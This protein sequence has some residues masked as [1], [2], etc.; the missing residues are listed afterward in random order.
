MAEQIVITNYSCGLASSGSTQHCSE[1]RLEMV[2]VV[3]RPIHIQIQIIKIYQDHFPHWRE[4]MVIA[5]TRSTK[6]S[7][8]KTLRYE[9]MFWF[10]APVARVWP[11]GPPGAR[12]WEETLDPSSVWAQ[13]L[14]TGLVLSPS[15]SPDLVHDTLILCPQFSYNCFICHLLDIIL[16]RIM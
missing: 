10:P 7:S 8:I 14:S 12:K 13:Q 4:Q 11:R 15:W 9:R 3:W 2:N 5:V 16:K 6:L 1:H